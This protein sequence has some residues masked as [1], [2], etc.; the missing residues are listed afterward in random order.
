MEEF[1]FEVLYCH[2]GISTFK[3]TEINRLKL[4]ILGKIDVARIIKG[5]PLTIT[6]TPIKYPKARLPASPI[7][8]LLGKALCHKYPIT[9]PTITKVITA[10]FAPL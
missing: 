7:R 4:C 2:L 9:T 3:E 5:F 6:Q 8:Q 1:S 10:Q